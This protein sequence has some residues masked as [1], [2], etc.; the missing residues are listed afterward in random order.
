VATGDRAG[1]AAGRA[2]AGSDPAVHC[3][4]ALS[5]SRADPSPRERGTWPT[6]PMLVLSRESMIARDLAAASAEAHIYTGRCRA[7]RLLYIRS[8][9]RAVGARA[10]A[11]R[12]ARWAAT[13]AI[14]ATWALAF[15]A[16][17]A[18]AALPSGAFVCST[19][20][21]FLSQANSSSGMVLYQSDELS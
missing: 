18:G 20:H 1:V 9:V 6:W 5:G 3:A 7:M 11:H 17:P 19:P 12:A 21:D 14:G 2:R 10:R 13:V 15:S 8:A 4:A 16:G